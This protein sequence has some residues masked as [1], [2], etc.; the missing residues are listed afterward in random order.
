MEIQFVLWN[1]VIL[2]GWQGWLAALMLFIV[3]SLAV[4]GYVSWGLIGFNLDAKKRGL[5][6]IEF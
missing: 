3:A 1:G 4:L 5:P 6:P 2:T